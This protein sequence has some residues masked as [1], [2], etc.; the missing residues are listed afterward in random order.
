MIMIVNKKRFCASL[1]FLILVLALIIVLVSIPLKKSLYPMEY[2]N[3]VETCCREYSL[4]KNLVYAVIKT[5]SNFKKD[6]LSHKGAKG[7]MQVTDDTAS[8]CIEKF[9]L[10]VSDDIYDERSNIIIGCA[11][12]SYLMEHFSGEISSAVAA[13][14]AGQGNVSKWLS[15]KRYSDDGKTLKKIPYEE[16]REYVKK[17]LKRRDIYIEMYEK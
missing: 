17:V 11:Y 1:S 9:N 8:W 16:T 5:E 3:V 13:Y 7:L 12:P 4:D 6:A 2:K 14:N 10:S 15:D